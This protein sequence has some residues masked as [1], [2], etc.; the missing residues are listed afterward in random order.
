MSSHGCNKQR[1]KSKGE[2]DSSCTVINIHLVMVDHAWEGGNTSC[3][4]PLT[5]LSLRRR[6]ERNDSFPPD[7]SPATLSAPRQPK[8]AEQLLALTLS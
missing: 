6:N 1:R 3:T 5:S 2:D 4:S 7:V 8:Q